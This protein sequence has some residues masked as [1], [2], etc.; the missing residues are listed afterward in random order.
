MQGN[1]AHSTFF[2]SQGGLGYA[3]TFMGVCVYSEAKRR[4]NL[5][6]EHEVRTVCLGE[7]QQRTGF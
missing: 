3:M 6:R 2:A 1:A 5:K 7:T 4:F